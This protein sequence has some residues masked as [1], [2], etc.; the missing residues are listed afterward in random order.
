MTDAADN[1]P[2]IDP[3]DTARVGR[4]QRLQRGGLIF[5]K[6]EIVVSHRKLPTFGGLTYSPAR[7]GIPFTG[8]EPKPRFVQMST[9]SEQ[10]VVRYAS[11]SRASRED[12]VMARDPLLFLRIKDVTDVAGGMGRRSRFL[13]LM[14]ECFV[15]RAV[16]LFKST[17]SGLLHCAAALDK[18]VDPDPECLRRATR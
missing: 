12:R 14:G 17:G 9:P 11:E 5:C 4:Q 7:M 8:P 6:P 1:A 13:S 3:W 10:T 16:S 18:P 2:V 15:S